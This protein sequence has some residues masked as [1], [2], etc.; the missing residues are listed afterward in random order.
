MLMG[1]AK[2]TSTALGAQPVHRGLFASL[3]ERLARRQDSEHQAAFIRIA[4]ALISAGYLV[5]MMRM[6][7]TVS[8]E[9]EHALALVVFFVPFSFAVLISII[10]YPEASTL[11]RVFCMVID[12][13]GTTY[14]LYFLNEIATPFIGLYLFNACGNGF[15]YGQRYLYLSSALSVSGFTFVLVASEY[16]NAHR[17]MGAGILIILIV[18][19]VYL[20]SLVQQLHTALARMHTMAT[21]DTLTGLPNRHAFYERL[22]F[23]LKSA[24]H[25]HSQFAVVFVDLD[26]FKPVNDE[27]GHAA[28]DM[29]LKSVARRLKEN[30]RENDVVARFGGDEFVLILSDISKAAVPTIA[31]KIIA[32]VARPYELNGEVVSL[33]SSAGIAVYPD[34]GRL[35]DELIT[36]ADTAMYR[37][38]RAGR[39]CFCRNDEMQTV[40]ILCAREQKR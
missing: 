17:A 38:K 18:I 9:D 7:I 27:L 13:G 11:R 36:C 20:T 37:S 1:T 25:N 19:P 29:V 16:W 32:T 28:G 5:I 30:V 2:Q 26:G 34:D 6:N 10:L 8:T 12:I 21:R 31:H 23:A 22:H 40:D 4:I 24:E 14:A 3:R 35:V 39:N 15:R 33:T